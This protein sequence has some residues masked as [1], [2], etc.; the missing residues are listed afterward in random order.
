M[1]Q[2]AALPGAQRALARQRERDSSPRR[3]WPRCCQPANTG[4][5]E[6]APQAAHLQRAS[7]SAQKV[8]C[9]ARE[10]ISSLAGRST[11]GAQTGSQNHAV[12]AGFQT[13]ARGTPPSAEVRSRRN[14]A[15]GEG[16]PPAPTG[17]PV[18]RPARRSRPHGARPLRDATR[19]TGNV[20]MT[21][22][23][24]LYNWVLLPL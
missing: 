23:G 5:W 16:P 6:S 13:A 2:S 1:S 20:S 4:P 14:E 10:R 17:V 12:Q 24:W 22:E 19:R 7:Q 3:R 11:R 8:S 15:A 9:P 21:P 18:N